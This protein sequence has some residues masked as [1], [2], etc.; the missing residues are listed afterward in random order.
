MFH[1]P[2]SADDPPFPPLPQSPVPATEAQ[3]IQ[4]SSQPSFVDRYHELRSYSRTFTL[5]YTRVQAFC[6]ELTRYTLFTAVSCIHNY[7]N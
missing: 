6:S 2:A 7:V 4:H 1:F 5:D 3:G